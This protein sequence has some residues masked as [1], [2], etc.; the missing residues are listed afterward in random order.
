MPSLSFPSSKPCLKAGQTL[1]LHLWLRGLT[2]ELRESLISPCTDKSDGYSAAHTLL[3]R[4][5]ERTTGAFEQRSHTQPPCQTVCLKPALRVYA[6]LRLPSGMSGQ[7]PWAPGLFGMAKMVTLISSPVT[8]SRQRETKKLSAENLAEIF[9]PSD[10]PVWFVTSLGNILAPSNVCL[11]YNWKTGCFYQ[12]WKQQSGIWT[13]R[14][15][16]THKLTKI[17]KLHAARAYTHLQQATRISTKL[18]HRHLTDTLWY[19]QCCNSCV[20]RL[21]CAVLYHKKVTADISLES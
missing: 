16:F 7:W 12:V 20:H 11:S 13:F 15:K 21:E 14:I 3:W 1:I 9:S 2:D 5:A 6:L 17:L 18:W 4:A 19:I 8:V 10:Q